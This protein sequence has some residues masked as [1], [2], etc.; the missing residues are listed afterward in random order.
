M[1]SYPGSSSLL[2]RVS[3]Q[4]LRPRLPWPITSRARQPQV[5]TPSSSAGAAGEQAQPPPTPSSSSKPATPEKAQSTAGTSSKDHASSSSSSHTDTLGTPG[6]QLSF[7]H[8][9]LFTF[10][11]VGGAF[12]AT[13]TLQVCV[14]VCACMTVHG[15]RVLALTAL[16]SP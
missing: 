13:V 11:F 14:G 7:I 3:A 15:H 16:A 10:I 6:F 8:V 1:L 12:F 5:S 2:R 4:C 9:A